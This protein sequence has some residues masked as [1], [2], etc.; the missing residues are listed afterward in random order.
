MEVL[1][2]WRAAQH[3]TSEWRCV[4]STGAGPIFHTVSAS[5]SRSILGVQQVASLPKTEFSASILQFLVQITA[6]VQPSLARAQIF[7]AWVGSWYTCS[8][9][10][11]YTREGR[12]HRYAV[13][14]EGVEDFSYLDCHS[15]E[16][17]ASHNMLA[18]IQS[19]FTKGF[20]IVHIDWFPSPCPFGYKATC[21][22]YEDIPDSQYLYLGGLV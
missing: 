4:S 21:K 1:L 3:S 18:N 10:G 9:R 2:C 20:D 13:L 14:E 7:Q 5:N 15:I 19:P 6:L 11:R 16:E 17:G 12:G 22:I 8:K